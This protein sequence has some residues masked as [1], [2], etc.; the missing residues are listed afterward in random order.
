MPGISQITFWAEDLLQS[1]FNQDQLQELDTNISLLQRIYEKI[2]LDPMDLYTILQSAVE[3][4]Q[5]EDQPFT[6]S[7]P[8][9]KTNKKGGTILVFKRGKLY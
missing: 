8:Y 3:G 9:Q 4:L 5:S 1:F 6:N 7:F 2:E